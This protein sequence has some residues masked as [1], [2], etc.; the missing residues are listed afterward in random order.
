VDRP[1]LLSRAVF[2]SVA[3]IAISAVVGTVS[4]VVALGT[5]SLSLLGFGADAVIDSAAS[6][7]LV[8]RFRTEIHQPHRADRIERVAERL[9]GFVLLVLAGYLAMS[10]ATAIVNGSQPD[11]S[12]LRVILLFVGLAVLPPLAI[13]KRQTAQSLESAALRAD[14]I[15]T[16][17]AAVLALIG[18]VALGLSELAHVKWGDA[19]GALVVAAIVAREGWSAF[20]LFSPSAR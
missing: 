15:L 20:G 12:I 6:V 8:W 3:S 4:V 9:V 16:A 18:L 1:S 2:L 13:A 7:I 19:I 10:A 5:Q 11:A 14:S 17:V